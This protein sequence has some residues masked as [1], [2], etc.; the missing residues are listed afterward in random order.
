MH[1]AVGHAL[2]FPGLADEIIQVGGMV[3]RLVAVGVLSNQAGDI[4][5]FAAGG[6]R[7]GAEEAV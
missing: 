2:G 6:E 4:H 7:V 5:L 3:A 1:D